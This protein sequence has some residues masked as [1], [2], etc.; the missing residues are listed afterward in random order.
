MTVELKPCPRCNA[1]TLPIAVQAGGLGQLWIRAMCSPCVLA[2]AQER[3]A[4]SHA[5]LASM[6]HERCEIPFEFAGVT[7]ASHPSPGAREVGAA[8]VATLPDPLGDMLALRE[9]SGGTDQRLHLATLQREAMRGHRGIGIFGAQG[10]GK[11]GLY[12]GIARELERRGVSSVMANVALLL[13]AMR[14][15]RADGAGQMRLMRPLRDTAYLVL[16]DIDKVSNATFGG[17]PTS[18]SQ[19]SFYALHALLEYRMEH[20]LP[21]GVTANRSLQQLKTEVFASFEA[22]GAAFCDRFL[23]TTG[24][25]YELTAS[26]SLRAL[27]GAA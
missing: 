24:S 14:E 22:D 18:D 21:I 13:E 6:V 5:E 23:K 3:A 4:K 9:W 8:Y 11:T 12:A 10:R 1:P 20:R 25:W 7:I 26:R 17:K 27:I 2:D 15:C 19:R 16:D